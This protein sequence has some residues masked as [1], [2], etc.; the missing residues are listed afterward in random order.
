[1]F[2]FDASSAQ[3]KYVECKRLMF[4]SYTVW[5]RN[6]GKYNPNLFYFFSCFGARITFSFVQFPSSHGNSYQFGE[7]STVKINPPTNI[8]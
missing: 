5:L 2:P 7:C 3:M 4:V 1:M 6:A 8:F